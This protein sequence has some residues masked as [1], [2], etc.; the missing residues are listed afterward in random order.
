MPHVAKQQT[1]LFGYKNGCGTHAKGV[2]I[3]WRSARMRF[4]PTWPLA[5]VRN[6]KSGIVH[7]AYVLLHTTYVCEILEGT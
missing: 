7:S 2:D 1:R 3:M 5:T 6:E 4:S